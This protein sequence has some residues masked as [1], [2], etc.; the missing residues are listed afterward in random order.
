TAPR[1]N[2]W[3]SPSPRASGRSCGA[4]SRAWG[5]RRSPSASTCPRTPSA[6]TCRTSS[7]NW[8]STPRSP[9][10]PSP[11]ARAWARPTWGRRPA[12]R[13]GAAAPARRAQAR[14]AG[15]RSA[16]DVVERGGELPEQSGQ[17][18][19]LGGGQL[20]EDG[21]LLRQQPGQGLVGPVAADVRE[22][23]QDTA[24]VTGVREAF[25]QVLLGQPVDA[26]GHGARGD[27]GLREKL[28]GG[29]LVRGPG[30]AQRRQDVEL[31]GFQA[32]LGERQPT[33]TVQMPGE[34]AHP[35]EHFEWFHVEV[36]ALPAPRCDQPIDLVL[37]GDQCSG[38]VDVKSRDVESLDVERSSG[39]RWYSSP[40]PPAPQEAP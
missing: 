21:A 12:S 20:R 35:A 36:R 25:H 37:H 18:A 3:W 38:C 33:G 22:T 14:A 15:R 31:P 40:V 5:A 6:P 29:E 23:D 26:V 13:R 32:V 28:S 8:A 39:G 11:A 4:W 7:A 9:P 30:P 19:A 27:E 16:G 34:P 10:S 17:F 24:P 1:A 2:G